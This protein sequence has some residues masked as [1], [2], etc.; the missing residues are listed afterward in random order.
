[1]RVLIADD[2]P[3]FRDA[4]SA[5]VQRVFDQSELIHAATL[6]TAL[7][8]LRTEPVDLLL[9]DLHMAD[10][11][12]FAGLVTVRHDWPALPVVIISASEGSDVIQQALAFGAAGYIP[13]STSLDTICEALSVVVDGDIWAPAHRQTDGDTDTATE[14]LASLTPAQLKVLLGMRAGRLNKQIA[15]DLGITEATVKAHVTAIFRKLGVINR[16]QAVLFAE[17]LDVERPVTV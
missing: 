4:L 15:Y 11:A 8:C 7:A 3:L 2:H 6:E 5:A 13:K 1:M 17:K 12:G 10:S 14:K 9:L 16:T